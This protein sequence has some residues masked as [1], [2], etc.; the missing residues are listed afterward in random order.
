MLITVCPASSTAYSIIRCRLPLISKMGNCLF[1]TNC[2][3]RGMIMFKIGY[4]GGRG[5]NNLESLKDGQ[6]NSNN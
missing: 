3:V 5:G 4:S 2:N 6:D 1:F